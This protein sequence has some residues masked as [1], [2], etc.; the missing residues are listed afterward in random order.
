[1]EQEQGFLG[2]DV[3]ALAVAKVVCLVRILGEVISKEV[4]EQGMWVD[5]WEQSKVQ[6]FVSYVEIQHSKGDSKQPSK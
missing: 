4:W 1:M 3:G 2:K 6:D 5:L